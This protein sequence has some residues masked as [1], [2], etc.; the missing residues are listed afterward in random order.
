M[1]KF[2]LKAGQG[3]SRAERMDIREWKGGKKDH[4]APSSAHGL[5]KKKK[6]KQA[7]SKQ[8]NVFFWPRRGEVPMT[9]HIIYVLCKTCPR[10][11]AHACFNHVKVS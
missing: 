9:K 2:L 8:K 4:C 3:M 7:I 5:R 11:V 6:Y 10:V 1:G